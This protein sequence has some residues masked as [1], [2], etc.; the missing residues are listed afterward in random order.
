MLGLGP[1]A[2]F[3]GGENEFWNQVAM[4]IIIQIQHLKKETLVGQRTCH[5][6]DDCCT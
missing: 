3:F 6:L 5:E 4:N 2:L 1:K